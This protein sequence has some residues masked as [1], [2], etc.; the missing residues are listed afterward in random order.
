MSNITVK[1]KEGGQYF[2]EGKTVFRITTAAHPG[3]PPETNYEITPNS[4]KEYGMVTTKEEFDKKYASHDYL[5]ILA[6]A[7]ITYKL[8]YIYGCLNFEKGVPRKEVFTFWYRF[9]GTR[10]WVEWFTVQPYID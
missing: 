6:M 2:R 8:A 9:L 10:E 7:P 1:S 5:S 3:A 4:K